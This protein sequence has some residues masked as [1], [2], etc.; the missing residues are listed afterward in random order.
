[1]SGGQDANSREFPLRALNPRARGALR[2]P[3]VAQCPPRR[4][5]R[6]VMPRDLEQ[7]SCIGST[8]AATAP[9]WRSLW[10]WILGAA[11]ALLYLSSFST[12]SDGIIVG[13]DVVYYADDLIG[14]CDRPLMGSPN[15]LG[16]HWLC[17]LVYRAMELWP[18]SVSGSGLALLAQQIV[19]AVGGGLTI[20]AIARMSDRQAGWRIALPLSCALALTKGVWFSSAVGDSYLP[21]MGASAWLLCSALGP[22][23]GRARPSGVTMFAWLLA[24]VLIR[25]DAILVLPAL[26]VLVPWRRLVPVAAGAGL[27]ALGLYALAWTNFAPDLR[28]LHW[29][30]GEGTHGMWGHGWSV[31]GFRLAGWWLICIFQPAHFQYPAAGWLSVSLLFAAFLL[32]RPWPASA[33]RGVVACAIYG[34]SCFGFYA[35]WQAE[36][37]EYQIPMLLPCAAAFALLIRPAT[38]GWRR[39]AQIGLLWVLAAALCIGTWVSSIDPYRGHEISVRSRLALE[40]AGPDGAVFELDAWQ[41]LAM[42]R[43]RRYTLGASVNAISLVCVQGAAA[44]N[45]PVAGKELRIELINMAKAGRRAVLIGDQVLPPEQIG[46]DRAD[47]RVVMRI[48][49]GIRHAPVLDGHGIVV[50]HVV[51]PDVH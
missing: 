10:P 16:Y 49:R 48:L 11:C 36:N 8:P 19:G 33:L 14:G 45:R 40:A 30:L 41:E 47:L 17:L 6:E 22:A 31:E 37:W 42:I 27:S 29:L 2:L 21:A 13:N 18:G 23:I 46:P 15:H 24:S 4:C 28:F 7:E 12:R 26:A 9:R 5:Y 34:F 51:E 3:R 43:E 38:R 20:V 50:A 39:F 32:A 44:P 35:W 1:M 25:Q